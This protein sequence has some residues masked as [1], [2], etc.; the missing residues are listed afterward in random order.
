MQLSAILA[1]LIL[2]TTAGTAAAAPDLTGKRLSVE[3]LDP[4]NEITTHVRPGVYRITEIVIEAGV[5]DKPVRA[6]L[7]TPSDGDVRACGADASY[8]GTYTGGEIELKL[9]KPGQDPKYTCPGGYHHQLNLKIARNGA[10]SGRW[11]MASAGWAWGDGRPV[12]GRCGNCEPGAANWTTEMI[13]AAVVALLI[14]LGYRGK[15]IEAAKRAAVQPPARPPSPPV[16]RDDGPSFDGLELTEAGARQRRLEDARRREAEDAARRKREDAEEAARQRARQLAARTSAAEDAKRK[17][18]AELERRKAA[19]DAD[20]KKA[21]QRKALE[22]EREQLR[23]RLVKASRSLVS[24]VADPERR[25]FYDSF[26]K[27]HEGDPLKLRAAIDAVRTQMSAEGERAASD[28]EWWGGFEKAATDI[29]D[30]SMRANRVLALGV[31]GGGQILGLQG[32]ATSTAAAAEDGARSTGKHI[33]R[34]GVDMITGGMAT[35]IYDHNGNVIKAVGEKAAEYDPREYL[36]RLK[37]A[38][39]KFDKGQWAEA[40]GEALD[41][42]LD[43]SDSGSDVKNRLKQRSASNVHA[44]GAGAT[45]TAGTAS[46]GGVGIVKTVQD[47]IMPGRRKKKQD[48]AAQRKAAEA[49]RRA[50]ARTIIAGPGDPQQRKLGEEYARKQFDADQERQRRARADAGRRRAVDEEKWRKKAAKV[51]GGTEIGNEFEKGFKGWD[52]DKPHIWVEDLDSTFKENL[53]IL[54]ITKKQ[55]GESPLIDKRL[56]VGAEAANPRAKDRNQAG[57]ASVT[58]SNEDSGTTNYTKKFKRLLQEPFNDT[59]KGKATQKLLEFLGHKGDPG[60]FIDKSSLWVPAADQAKARQ[61]VAR[62]IFKNGSYNF[63]AF[64][65]YVAHLE[66]TRPDLDNPTKIA[67]ELL[68]KIEG[69]TP[70]DL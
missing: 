4:K 17:A 9:K 46:K 25:R 6:R 68:S 27:R 30:W 42:A 12:S 5:P 29:R 59:E 36:K 37:E 31:P 34:T 28:A 70:W 2:L 54:D 57:F 26:L 33:L 39:K 7:L 16:R 41:T 62:M 45:S 10:V 50:A 61:A 63:T 11:H 69:R 35:K 8:I 58:A 52:R 67:R 60:G 24:R 18:R 47:A 44:T 65:E 3:W 14:W 19:A 49:E 1:L 48:P 51:Q 20:A 53:N 13:V 64:S 38:K 55:G 22:E 21:Q 23:Q 56:Y 32:L 15:Q 66:A 40:A 43:A